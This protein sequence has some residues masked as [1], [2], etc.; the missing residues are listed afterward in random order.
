LVIGMALAGLRNI[1][2]EVEAR[3]L[4]VDAA[5]GAGL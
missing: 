4:A 3:A 2:L 5:I 1:G